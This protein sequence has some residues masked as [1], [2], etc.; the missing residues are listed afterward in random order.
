MSVLRAITKPLRDALES[1]DHL[2][3][4]AKD[5]PVQ[6]LQSTLNGVGQALLIG[7]RLRSAV[8]RRAGDESRSGQGPIDETEAPTAAGPTGDEERPARRDPVIFSPRPKKEA[9]P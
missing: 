3:A 7:D 8:K 6:M 4:K 2:R 1:C 5:L 9:E